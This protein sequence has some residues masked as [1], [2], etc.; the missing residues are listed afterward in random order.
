VPVQ[1]ILI[2]LL[3]VNGLCAVALFVTGALMSAN[4][5]AYRALLTVHRIAPVLAVI[6]G[7]AAIYLLGS[8]G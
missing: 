8:A 5:P 7:A 6:A 4:R 2:A 1:P 3:M